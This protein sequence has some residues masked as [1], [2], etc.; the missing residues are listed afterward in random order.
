MEFLIVMIVA[1]AALAGGVTYAVTRRDLQGG[2]KVAVPFAC[3]LLVGVACT[4]VPHL[5]LFAF[6]GTVVVHLLVRRL[7]TA[8][9]ALAASGVVLLGGC[10]FSV[11]L[12]MVALETM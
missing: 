7:L 2:A 10:S 3:A 8:K 9:L 11:L 1:S 5:P 6:L 4:F 12:M